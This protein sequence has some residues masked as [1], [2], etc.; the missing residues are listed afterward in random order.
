MELIA[1]IICLVITIGCTWM[2][3]DVVHDN[4]R[5]MRENRRLK[6]HRRQLADQLQTC[7]DRLEVFIESDWADEDDQDAYNGALHLASLVRQEEERQ[8]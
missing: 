8:S 1:C 2:L 3:T 5:L 4:R 6:F 7:A